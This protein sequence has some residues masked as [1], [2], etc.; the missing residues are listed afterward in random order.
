MPSSTSALRPIFAD[1]TAARSTDRCRPSARPD[2]TRAKCGYRFEDDELVEEMLAEVEGERGAL[3]LLAFAAARL[4]EKR[5]RETGLLTRQA[6][7]DI[8]GVGGA[9]AQHAEATIDRIGSERIPIVRELFR[10]LVTAEGTRAV[11]EWDELLS[12]FSDSHSESPEEVLREL[13]DARLLTSYEIHEDEHEPTRRVEIIHESLLANWPRLVRWQTQDQTAPSSATSC[14]R[15]HA[16]GTS[17]VVPTTACG[18]GP[19]TASISSWRERY[20]GGLTDIE[21]DFGSAMTSLA[22]R[23]R[24]RRRIVVAAGLQCSSP[25]LASSG[26]SG[27]AASVETRRAEAQKLIA[28]GQIRLEDDPTAALAHATKS[29]EL[30]DSEEARFLALKALWEGPTAFVVNETPALYANFSPDGSWLVQ[31]H[32]FMSSVSVI[33]RNGR[34]RSMDLPTE[35]GKSRART[36]FGGW[37]NVFFSKGTF[38]DKGHMALWSAPD[39][40]LLWSTNLVDDPPDYSLFATTGT[41][42]EDGHALLV[43]V[44]GTLITVDAVRPG[45]GD[46]RL[47]EIHMKYPYSEGGYPCTPRATGEWLGLVEGNDISIV[48]VGDHGLSD[49]VLLGRQEGDLLPWCEADP[50]ERFLLTATRSG[51]FRL[52][53]VIGN[54][55]PRIFDFQEDLIDIWFSREGSYLIAVTTPD[56]KG[57]NFEILSIDDSGLHHLRHMPNVGEDVQVLTLIRSGCGSPGRVHP[58]RGCCG[59]SRLRQVRNPCSSVVGRG[60]THIRWD[61]APMG[62]GL[63]PLIKVV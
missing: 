57:A 33:S 29:L 56:Q 48:R 52:W 42:P 51:E 63:P 2:P 24:R 10:N 62:G 3:P 32:D 36:S 6:Y 23:R 5:D 37:E 20:P 55:A 43:M 18:P 19:R 16:R 44:K 40:R 34:Q 11:R 31:V 26:S 39:G 47:A 9:L 12:I 7:H 41:G 45:N 53:D 15:R 35:S 25:Y 21:E 22:G 17:K 54:Q 28:M 30:A 58:R 59:R 4:W 27:S 60:V 46:E 1:L 8:G 38:G 13:I 14:D 50:Q 49:R 61:S